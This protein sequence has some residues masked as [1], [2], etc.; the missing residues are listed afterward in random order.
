MFNIIIPAKNVIDNTIIPAKNVMNSLF[1]T[2][3]GNKI[4]K[5]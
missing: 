1:Y 5:F 3:K 2:K 4:Q